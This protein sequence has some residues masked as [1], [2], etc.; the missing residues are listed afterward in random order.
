[1]K[2]LTDLQKWRI[3]ATKKE[4]ERLEEKQA[5]LYKEL[6]ESLKEIGRD[7]YFEGYLFD[8]IYNDFSNKTLL[9]FLDS[10]PEDIE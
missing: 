8:Y 5:I 2:N 1:M 3:T 9:E 7:R 10:V 4:V 6:V